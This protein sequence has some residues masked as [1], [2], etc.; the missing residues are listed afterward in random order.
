M[1]EGAEGDAA[2][3]RIEHDLYFLGRIRPLPDPEYRSIQEVNWV[4]AWKQHYRPLRVGRRLAIVPAWE[5]NPHPE[6]LSIRI[7]PGM[8]FGTG[9]HPSTQLALELIE[10]AF[11][12]ETPIRVIDIGCGSGVLAIAAVLMGSQEVV[13]V[14]IDEDARD[15]A[16]RPGRGI[17]VW[18]Y[19]HQ[20]DPDL[21]F[22][23]F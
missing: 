9:T 2:R 1:A 5:E 15:N 16:R 6:T 3:K 12:V 17:G 13:A 4:D 7:D 14:D 18:D 19:D 20:P 21:H 23:C 11:D 8:A 10:S 22:V